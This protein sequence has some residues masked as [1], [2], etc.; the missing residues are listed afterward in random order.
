MLF[1]K[2][3]KQAKDMETSLFDTLWEKLLMAATEQLLEQNRHN[4]AVRRLLD[5]IKENG[6][7]M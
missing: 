2:K 4:Q 1:G 3:I 7:K 5:N 6:C